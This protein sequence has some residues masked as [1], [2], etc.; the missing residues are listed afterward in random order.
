MEK[1]SSMALSI[2]YSNL[3]K[4]ADKQQNPGLSGRYGELSAAYR[5]REAA[6]AGG[7]TELAV[8]IRKDLEEGIPAALAA[9]EKSV[10]RGALRALKWGEK[11]SKIDAS[12]ISRFQK[13]GE[14][15]LEEKDLFVCQACGFIYLG[16]DVPE[17][18]PVCK[19]PAS[20][21]TQVA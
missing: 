16:S 15:L 3:E 19:A 5:T 17:I 12:L 6:A 11:V 20:R 21:F 2:I 14:A 1:R 18:C 13:Q 10:D 4:A 7:L 8:L 9:A